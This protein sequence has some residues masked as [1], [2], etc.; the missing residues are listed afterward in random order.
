MI[1]VV[2]TIIFMTTMVLMMMLMELM[3]K[4]ANNAKVRKIPRPRLGRRCRCSSTAHCPL[5]P[6]SEHKTFCVRTTTH[7]KYDMIRHNKI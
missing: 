7:S 1:V 2:V 4:L 6:R 3:T 5:T